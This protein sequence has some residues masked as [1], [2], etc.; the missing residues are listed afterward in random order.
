MDHSQLADLLAQTLPQ[1]ASNASVNRVQSLSPRQAFQSHVRTVNGRS[2]A[3]T[4]PSPSALRSPE[5]QQFSNLHVESTGPPPR[6]PA[7]Q[8]PFYGYTDADLH[9]ARDG[10]PAFVAEEREA[11]ARPSPLRIRKKPSNDIY[12]LQ[13]P[14]QETPVKQP[15]KE[16]RGLQQF[17]PMIDT[18][19]LN[20]RPKTSRGPDAERASSDTHND[21]DNHSQQLRNSKFAEGSMSHRSAGVSSTWHKHGSISSLSDLSDDEVTPKAS[22]QRSSI[23]VDEFKPPAVTPSTLKQR[24]FKIGPTFKHNEK[25]GKTDA[26]L[27]GERKKKGLRKSISMW[28]LSHNGDKKKGRGADPDRDLAAQVATSSTPAL[29]DKDTLN[30]RKRRAEEAY[31]QQFGTKRRKSTGNQVPLPELSRPPRPLPVPELP[32][33]TPRVHRPKPSLSSSAIA[34]DSELSD[35]PSGIDHHKRPSRRELEKE[36]QQLRA[37]LKQ[38]QTRL[39]PDS[40]GV[41]PPVPAARTLD[42]LTNDIDPSKTRSASTSVRKQ[43]LPP[44][45][46]VPDRVAL[47]NL[48]NIRNQPKNK[49][50]NTNTPSPNTNPSEKSNEQGNMERRPLTNINIAGLSRPVSVILEED[51]EAIENKTPTPSPKRRVL[52]P[53]SVEKRKIRDQIA[54]QLRGVRREQWEW[55]EDVF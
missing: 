29:V 31:A 37:M 48:S 13:P 7:R 49:T 51:E 34:T 6:S 32:P 4:K 3:T 45:P 38:Q 11:W 35:G 54:I 44:V 9:I 18:A 30:E 19:D 50:S 5:L 1:K 2:S 40:A 14:E 21:D 27:P 39:K 52:E 22:P 10:Q 28:N 17:G 41:V 55:P 33:K 46:P 23:D 36:N 8:T 20:E 53:S 16:T 25:G 15:S 43:K 12:V 24:L 42:D 47:R 26:P